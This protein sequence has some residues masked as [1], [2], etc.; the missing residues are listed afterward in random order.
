[1]TMTK[2][3]LV[4]DD[5][6]HIRRILH[7]NLQRAGYTVLVSEDGEAALVTAQAERPDLVILD[8]AM[9]A[10]IGSSRNLSARRRCLTK[11]GGPSGPHDRESDRRPR[12]A[13]APP[14]SAMKVLIVD[15]DALSRFVLRHT[16]AAAGHEIAA[17][18]DGQEAWETLQ[19]ERFEVVICDWMMP[20]VDG[21]ELT[22]RIRA[23][24]GLA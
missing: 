10:P 4:A 11:C 13:R 9:P 21:L 15:D 3:V 5:E 24:G 2:R 22:R 23:D 17:A 8:V 6:S 12:A 20:N 7:F 16:L 18:A 19:R 1:M 14:A